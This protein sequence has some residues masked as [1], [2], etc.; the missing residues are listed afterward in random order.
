[1]SKPIIKFQGFA[2]FAMDAPSENRYFF[3]KNFWSLILSVIVSQT[4]IGVVIEVVK[5]QILQ[6]V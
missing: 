5:F 1:M 6:V 2:I 3:T 4:H